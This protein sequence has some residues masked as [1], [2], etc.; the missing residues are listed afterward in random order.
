MSVPGRA[1]TIAI[2]TTT[3]STVP[4]VEAVGRVAD[5]LRHLG[6][7][8]KR[9][10]LPCPA[11]DALPLGGPG[12]LHLHRSA[13]QHRR[14]RLDIQQPVRRSHRPVAAL[15]VVVIHGEAPSPRQ[16]PAEARR[17]VD[18]DDR[19]E[20][21]RAPRRALGG[22]LSWLP[23]P[24]GD[25]RPQPEG[26]CGPELQRR[27]RVRVLRR[28]GQGRADRTASASRR[29]A[30]KRARRDALCR[31]PPAAP[32]GFETEQH[33]VPGADGSFRVAGDPDRP[34]RLR[35]DTVAG[36]RELRAR[37]SG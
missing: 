34:E 2:M 13:V 4:S 25:H 16:A 12:R 26:H 27:Q 6:E 33:L 7:T 18:L 14:H 22:D 37:L 8:P 17:R 9:R 28:P 36:W 5:G 3:P 1:R 31:C 10:E 21:G 15:E 11:D 23:P 20:R 29:R 19:R 30:R 35:F 24:P 32:D